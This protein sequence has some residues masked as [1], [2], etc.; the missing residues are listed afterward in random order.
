MIPDP[1]LLL[2]P[3]K[4]LGVQREQGGGQPGVGGSGIMQQLLLEN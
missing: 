3:W 1:S 4:A 2:L